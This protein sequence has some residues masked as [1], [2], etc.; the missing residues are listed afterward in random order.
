MMSPL[1]YGYRCQSCDGTVRPKTVAC[2]AF[3]HKHGF[4]ILKD[5]P[6]GLCD[7]CGMRYYHSGLLHRVS[8]VANGRV[9]ADE[10]LAVP[11]AQSA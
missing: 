9:A 1:P 4:V 6:I 2:E 10:T 3:K 5:V 8:D 7:N 11:V